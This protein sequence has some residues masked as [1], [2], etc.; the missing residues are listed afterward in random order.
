MGHIYCDINLAEWSV[1]PVYSTVDLQ[2]R[3]VGAGGGGMLISGP[4]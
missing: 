2:V 3:A 1:D 4:D